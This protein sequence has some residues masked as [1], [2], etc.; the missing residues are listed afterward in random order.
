MSQPDLSPDLSSRGTTLRNRL[1]VAHRHRSSCSAATGF[2]PDRIGTPPLAAGLH[3]PPVLGPLGY[4]DLIRAVEP[5]VRYEISEPG[6]LLHLDTKRLGRIATGPG[7]RAT[8]D[9][10]SRHLGIDWE[11]LHMAIDAAT[12]LV[13]AELLAD[14]KDRTTAVSLSGR[15]IGSGRMASPSSGF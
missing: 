10:T 1:T 6:G 2:G 4:V 8:C 14:E 13:Y 7:N 9:R 3:L 5:A 11:H 12:R 15:C